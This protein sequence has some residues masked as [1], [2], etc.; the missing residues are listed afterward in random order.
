LFGTIQEVAIQ[1]AKPGKKGKQK[2][3]G[4]VTFLQDDPGRQMIGSFYPL[5]KD[6]W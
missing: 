4:Q 1:G 2:L 3:V 6:D 5:T